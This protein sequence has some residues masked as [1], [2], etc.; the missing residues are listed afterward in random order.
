MK[1][2]RFSIAVL[3]IMLA[4]VANGQN[5]LDGFKVFSL[6]RDYVPIGAEW[7]NQVGVN[8]EG[9]PDSNI[10]AVKSINTLSIDKTTKMSLDLAILKLFNLDADYL[11][12]SVINYKNLRIFTVKDFSKTNMQ[13]GQL[14]LYEGLKADSI[15]LTLTKALEGNVKLQFDEKLKELKITDTSKFKN[16][17]TLNGDHLYLAYRIF[18][19]SSTKVTRKEKDIVNTNGGVVKEL[20]FM[21]YTFRFYT[22]KYEECIKSNLDI[23]KAI[24]DDYKDLCNK[25]YPIALEI[26]NFKNTNIDGTPLN[27]TRQIYNLKKQNIFF[28]K[29]ANSKIISDFIEVYFMRSPTNPAYFFIM[30]NGSKISVTRTETKLK[31]F[32]KPS[33][34]GW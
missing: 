28:T 23:N 33:A 14:I 16:T 30:E 31:M 17:I 34:P 6:P 15:S 12:T 18:E 3:L 10:T 2:I 11:K 20:N 32:K 22:A 19:L 5:F 24:R 4:S 26:Q 21:D 25:N 27:E 9:V 29:R 7:I 1:P 13:S 8:G